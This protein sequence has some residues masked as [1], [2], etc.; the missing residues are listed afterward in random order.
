MDI[1]SVIIVCGPPASGKSFLSKEIASSL[2]MPLLSKDAIK[3]NMY[4]SFRENKMINDRDI[5]IASYTILFD[6]IKQLVSAQVNFVVESNFDYV[7]SVEKMVEIRNEI[8]FRSMTI[9]CN[10]DLKTLHRRFVERDN[11]DER[12]PRLVTKKYWDFECFYEK[13]NEAKSFLFDI[14]GKK[15]SYDATEFNQMRINKVLEESK[16]FISNENKNT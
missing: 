8:D 1:S 12:H 3:I 13:Q 7:E 16:R 6:M 10:A 15:I 11:S 5:S 14:G 4:D 9:M 2:H